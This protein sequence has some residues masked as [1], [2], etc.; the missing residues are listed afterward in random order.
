[1]SAL[2]KD[3]TSYENTA[4]PSASL[5]TQI[6][7]FQSSGFRME[8]KPPLDTLPPL[9]PDTPA[10]LPTLYVD[11]VLSIGAQYQAKIREVSRELLLL[12]KEITTDDGDPLSRE[13]CELRKVALEGDLTI[14]QAI[15]GIDDTEKRLL[16]EKLKIGGRKGALEE[17][18]NETEK[19]IDGL[20]DALKDI[21]NKKADN[22]SEDRLR[23]LQGRARDLHEAILVGRHT[24]LTIDT[25]LVSNKSRE[26]LSQRLMTNTVSATEINVATRKLRDHADDLDEEDDDPFD[27][28]LHFCEDDEEG[29]VETDYRRKPKR[30]LA[31]VEIGAIF[32]AA[33]IAIL[34]PLIIF[35]EAETSSTVEQA[36]DDLY[37]IGTSISH[38]Y[39]NREDYS[40]LS[41]DLLIN[42]FLVTEF[43]DGDFQL[44]NAFDTEMT[45]QPS[46]HDARTFNITYHDVPVRYCQKLVNV[47]LGPQ[48]S[49][50]RIDGEPV[51]FEAQRQS[52]CGTPAPRTFTYTMY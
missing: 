2:K 39:A 51:N 20:T 24:L 16:V 6:A 19:A 13:V 42:S 1:M 23:D 35:T 5:K 26:S 3:N 44:T 27:Y 45:I 15:E 34:I 29:E 18:S 22:P 36:T 49:E 10:N 40:T 17:L 21:E 31:L 38:L 12:T 43:T 48:F 7:D 28:L 52:A 30:Q 9:A 14:D 4:F 37:D 25:A 8:A 50:L 11:E 32:A 47:N 33:M 41:Q 46:E